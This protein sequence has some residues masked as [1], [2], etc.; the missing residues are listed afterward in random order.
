MA[1]F[2]DIY[3]DAIVQIATPYS[4]GTGFFLQQHQVVVTNHH[5]VE[6]NRSVV[7]EGARFKKQL[8]EVLYL[9]PKYDLAFLAP[10][11]EAE[12]LPDLDLGFNVTV[13]AG[14]PITA[15]GHPFGLRFSVKKGLI[16]NARE[17]LD[18]GIPYLHIDAALNPG[19]SGG[20]L[21]DDSGRVIGVN[22]FVMRGSDNIGFSLPV[23][24]L[25]QSLEAF[26]KANTRNSARCQGCSNVV[27]PTTVQDN[28]CTYC[29]AKVRLPG[30]VEPYAP[31]GTA[32]TIERIIAQTDHDVALS[33]SGPNAWEIRQGSAKITISYHEKTGL[34]SAD[35]VLCQLPTDNIKPLYE[36]LLRENYQ[37]SALCLSVNGQDI[38]LSL[39]VYDR[40][41]NE[42]TGLQLLKNLFEKADYYDN[43]LVEQFGATWREAAA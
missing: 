26:H 6:D 10:P 19:N 27:T 2:I 8:V 35:A 41:L 7:I 15:F 24:F 21:S 5:V 14:D 32:R 4:T 40:Y 36:Y 1:D 38:L 20:P 28:C 12:S 39:L 42:T 23:E 43:V 17:V 18:N 31:A 34:M 9:D 22:T 3:R 30:N 11:R 33:R 37:N 25:V 13:K 16:S 29:G